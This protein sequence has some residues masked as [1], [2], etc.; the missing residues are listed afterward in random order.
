MSVVASGRIVIWQGASLWLFEIADDEADTAPHAHHAIQITLALDGTFE[1]I[2]AQGAVRGPA[3]AIAPDARHIFH[4]RGAAALLFIEP[5]SAAG[6]ALAERWFGEASLVA[7]DWAPLAAAADD[8]RC[9]LRSG[10]PDAALVAIGER[11]IQRFWAG[12]PGQPP[13]PR[14][15]AMVDFAG[16]NLDQPIT[17]GAAADRVH[18]SRSRASHLFVEQTGLP[19]KTYVLWRRLGKAVERYSSGE[20]LTEAAHAAGFADSAHL[21]RTFRRMFGLP[22]ASLRILRPQ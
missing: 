17:I 8:L 22:A 5:E 12:A 3:V 21:S 18:L 14:V 2:A 20:S 19:F 6:R 13:D 9:A 16:A 7:L 1:F 10:A 4:S 15:N 11:I